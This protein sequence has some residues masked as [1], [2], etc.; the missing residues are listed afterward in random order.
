[1][2][3]QLFSVVVGWEAPGV[4]YA[5][6]VRGLYRSDDC[7]LTWRIAYE[8]PLNS[9]GSRSRMNLRTFS[10]SQNGQTFATNTGIRWLQLSPDAG[11]TWHDSRLLGDGNTLGQLGLSPSDPNTLYAFGQY[12]IIEVG[13]RETGTVWRTT[14]GGQNWSA[15]AQKV[16][17]GSPMVDPLDPETVYLVGGGSVQRST[18]G[19]VSFEQYGVYDADVLM[20]APS[21]GQHLTGQAAMSADGSHMWFISTDGGFYRS[22]DRGIEWRRLADVPFGRRVLSVSASPHD[23]QTLFAVTD[24]DE[25][26]VYRSNDD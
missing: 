16:P 23:P 2:S 20:R 22:L 17:R 18:D 19:A 4:L 10:M 8:P 5:G 25:L 11:A 7:G 14:D 9:R 6:G 15:R 26:W 21:G 3:A 24:G 1:M 12:W 13:R